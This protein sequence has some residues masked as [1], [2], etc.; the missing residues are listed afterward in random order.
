MNVRGRVA[1][2]VAVA[3]LGVSYVPAQNR[4]AYVG[5]V[6]YP[7]AYVLTNDRYAVANT[8]HP[9]RHKPGPNYAAR[10]QAG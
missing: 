4:P 8:Y 7:P 1:L 9:V 6:H 3:A 2:A 10:R 5:P